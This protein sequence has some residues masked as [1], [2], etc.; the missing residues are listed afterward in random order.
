MRP[1]VAVLALVS[2]HGEPERASPATIRVAVIGG[3]IETGFWQELVARYELVSGNHVVLA[4]S[5]PKQIVI[6]AFRKGG[7]DLVTVHASDAMVNLVAD[8]LAVDPEPWLENDMVFVGPTDDPAHVRGE[9]DA[10]VALAKIVAAKAPLLVHASLGADGVLHDLAEAAHVTL[11]PSATVMF[12]GENQHE[13]VAR[14]AEL[15][16]YTLVGRIPYLD[17]KLRADG[18]DLMV[19]GDR[20][21]RRPYL[22]E[23]AVGAPAAARDLAAFM[24]SPATQAWIP[25]FGVGRHDDQPLFFPIARNPAAPSAH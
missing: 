22:V 11:D 19:R 7:I 15:H 5:G 23:T 12:N 4:A 2:C 18:I 14:A 24:R 1:L 10:T 3:M 8:G 17:G 21:L 16:A 9:P 20:R 6:D 25:T 13:V